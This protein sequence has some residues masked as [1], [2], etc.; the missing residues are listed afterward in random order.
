MPLPSLI[1]SLKDKYMF[2]SICGD[3]CSECPRYKAT[4]IN[5][6]EALM[7][8]AETW[9]RLGFRDKIVS[10]EE[11]K[12]LGCNKQK[13]CAYGL[14]NC[15]HLEDKNNCG[16]CNLFPCP[17][18]EVVFKKTALVEKTVKSLS[19]QAEYLHLKKVFFSKK[20]ILT[21]INQQK[22]L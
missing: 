9:F 12:C 21:G 13:P 1:K 6:Q 20:E 2:I 5:D 16:E 10:M 7:R 14:N 4:M 18:L 19:I 3:I 8:V 17:K 15:Q 22:K 11:I